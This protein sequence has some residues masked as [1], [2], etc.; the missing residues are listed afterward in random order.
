MQR[1]VWAEIDLRA[2]AHNMQEIRRITTAQSQVMAVVKANGYGHGALEVARTVLKHGADCL[3]V[4]ILAE[5]LA[6]RREGITAPIIILGYTPP[7]QATQVVANNLTQT[8]YDLDLAQAM[9]GAAQAGGCQARIHVKVDTGMGRIGVPANREGIEQIRQITT[10][11]GLVAEGIYTHLAKADEQDKS[12]TREQFQ[13]FQQ[14]TNTLASEG[15][16]FKVRHVAN[17]AALLEM[18]EL[19]LDLVRP[20]IMIYGLYPSTDVDRSKVNLQAAMSLKARVV[21]VKTVPLGTGLSYGLTYI[22]PKATEISS[23]PL[24]YADGYSRLYSN[25]ARVLI[26]GRSYP[27][28]G[29]VCM[30]Q[31]LVNTDSGGAVQTGDEVVLLGRQGAE[32]ITADELAGLIG[33]INYEIVCMI[34][35]RVPRVYI[36]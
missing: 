27:V 21:Y 26:R 7:Q 20:G 31:C 2:I 6:L 36:K 10:L 17:S 14:V 25:Q 29:R 8:V 30:D 11:P 33:T 22:T 9:S 16:K 34:S 5:G 18:P 13:R 19:H 3:G 24:G 23:L 35:E 1:P 32:E 12:F 4:A 15:I 28:V